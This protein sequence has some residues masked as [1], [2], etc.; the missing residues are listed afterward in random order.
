MEKRPILRNAEAFRFFLLV[1]ETM[2]AHRRLEAGAK[3]QK[4]VQQSDDALIRYINT[5]LQRMRML[6]FEEVP[7]EIV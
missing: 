3:N 2:R 6:G 7:E 1:V 4:Q 5:T